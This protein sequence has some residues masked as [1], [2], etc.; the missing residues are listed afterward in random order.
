MR[1]R[2]KILLLFLFAL[3]VGICVVSGEEDRKAAPAAGTGSLVERLEKGIA[4]FRSMDIQLETLDD[5]VI[6]KKPLVICHLI[7]I[8]I[9]NYRK[10]IRTPNKVAGLPDEVTYVPDE[11]R[12]FADFVVVPKESSFQAANALRFTAEDSRNVPP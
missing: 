10:E 7:F 9:H 12:E 11:V 4:P 5:P 3:T 6:A 8:R 1:R 2:I